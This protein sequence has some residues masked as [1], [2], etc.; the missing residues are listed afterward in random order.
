M[1]VK[2]L[3]QKPNSSQRELLVNYNLLIS[4][5]TY[6][7][8][9]GLLTIHCLWAHAGGHF[10]RRCVSFRITSSVAFRISLSSLTLITS[11]ISA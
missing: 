11:N 10:S 8:L 7:V 4:S 2:H 6:L 1:V 3:P 9:P 5:Y